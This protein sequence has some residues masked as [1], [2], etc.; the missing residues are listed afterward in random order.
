M[1]LSLVDYLGGGGAFPTT[2]PERA[3][4]FALYGLGFAAMAAAVAGLFATSLRQPLAPAV[5]AGITG[6]VA[7]WAMLAGAGLLSVLLSLP[8][9]TRALAPWVYALLPL[10]IGL[11]AWRKDWTG[12]KSRLCTQSACDE[13][14]WLIQGFCLERRR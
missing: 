14:A 2:G 11:Y 9:A 4:L 5:R 12:E 8:V 10:T 3:K 7:I 13:W 1:A 6:E